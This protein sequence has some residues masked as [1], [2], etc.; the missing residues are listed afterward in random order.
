MVSIKKLSL[1][2]NV[3]SNL[4]NTPMSN[5]LVRDALVLSAAVIGGFFAFTNREAIYELA[6]FHPQDLAQAA[7][8]SAAVVQI[9]PAVATGRFSTI[10]KAQDGHFWTEARINDKTQIKFLV[11]TGASIVALTTADARQIGLSPKT[12]TYDKP[13]NTAAGKVMAASV[14]LGRVTVGNVTVYNVRAVVIPKG[15]SH[16]LL[17]MSYLGQVRKL[18]ISSTELVLRQ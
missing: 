7:P 9:A 15:L 5:T 12:M 3:T 1:H 17:G 11:D 18:E 13:L 2:E 4:Y 10:P 6:G 16:S 8:E 14:E